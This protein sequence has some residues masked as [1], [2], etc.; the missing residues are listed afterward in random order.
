MRLGSTITE[1]RQRPD[2]TYPLGEALLGLMADPNMLC[3]LLLL[4]SLNRQ[5]V[6]NPGDSQQEMRKPFSFCKGPR[7]MPGA[8]KVAVEHHRFPLS[9]EANGTRQVPGILCVL[10]TIVHQVA[11]TR[12]CKQDRGALEGGTCV[13]NRGARNRIHCNSTKV[14]T[15]NR[16]GPL[17]TGCGIM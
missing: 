1:I 9:S 15:E 14:E 4:A 3:T 17:V 13:Q 7:E 8:K 5:E 6:L 10:G 16:C 12:P 11:L 2:G